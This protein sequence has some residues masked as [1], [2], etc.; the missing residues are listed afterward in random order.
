[1]ADIEEKA[2]ETGADLAL[3]GQND[4]SAGRT[5]GRL[6]RQAEALLVKVIEQAGY[7]E[8]DGNEFGGGE[9]VLYAFG[10]AADALFAVTEPG[11]VSDPSDSE[12]HVASEEH[13]A[14]G[15]TAL[16]L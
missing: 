7:G 11:S 12:D 3:E 2:T 16:G 13:V 5:H 6:F 8:F 14:S 15:R 4:A 10:P 1:M 9:A